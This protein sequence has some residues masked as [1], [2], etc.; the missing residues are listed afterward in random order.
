[1]WKIANER[2]ICY[3]IGCFLTMRTAEF[4]Y[5]LPKELIAQE[6][7]GERRDAKL[8]VLNRLE[9]NVTHSRFSC[10]GD[11]LRRGDLI[12]LNDS[13]VI[14]ARIPA[15]KSTG[16]AAEI[17]LTERLDD[18]RWLCLVRGVKRGVS[19]GEVTAGGVPVLLRRGD[20]NWIAMFPE[21][22]DADR[23]IAACG[24]PPLPHYIRRKEGDSNAFDAERYQTVY[25]AE[26][27]SI[28]APTAGLHFDQAMFCDLEAMG[29]TI[30][31][32]TLHIGIGTFLLI[33]T[34]VVEEHGM[35]EERF[36]MSMKTFEEV[37]ATKARGGRVIAVGT[38][39]VRT[40]ETVWASEKKPT[41]TG[42]TDLFIFPGY[43][44]RAVDG[45][46]TNFHLPRSTP[47]MLAAAFAG[48]EILHAA[49]KEAI[50]EHYRFY[51]YGD[52]MLIL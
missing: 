26:E 37:Q 3:K 39:A 34:D 24:Q 5:E 25:A 35:H 47:L 46:I 27:G 21:A 51:S 9:G 19:E 23:V 18:R 11:F 13:R 15:E 50:T 7:A 1:V 43:R 31:K 33:K 32:V 20:P 44:Y 48:K 52:A 28:A 36:S 30:R 49:Y 6:P 41:L 10:L 14:A 12:L 8:L 4:D 2:A 16:G 29:V 17:L 42:R 40:L 45:M 22:G 38:S